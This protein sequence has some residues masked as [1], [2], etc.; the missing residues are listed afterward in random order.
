M[1][2]REEAGAK[3]TGHPARARFLRELRDRAA[4]LSAAALAEIEEIPFDNAVYHV[5]VLE[6]AGVVEVVE[7]VPRGGR[8]VALYALNP[9]DLLADVLRRLDEEDESP[10][11]GPGLSPGT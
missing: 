8:M 3:L 6:N 10:G 1:A 5:R 11:S 7:R 9:G 4:P 2:E